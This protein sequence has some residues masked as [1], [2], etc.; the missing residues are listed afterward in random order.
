MDVFDC[1][2]K[3]VN[4]GNFQGQ[5]SLD[6]L[7]SSPRK[8]LLYFVTIQKL[9]LLLLHF[10]LLT[11]YHFNI[12]TFTDSHMH[13]HTARASFFFLFPAVLAFF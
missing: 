10:C 13:T 2:V 5:P 9:R 12:R 7:F 1:L 3:S 4:D 8:G 6:W 11:M